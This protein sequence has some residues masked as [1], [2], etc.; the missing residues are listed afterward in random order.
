MAKT[1]EVMLPAL[2]ARGYGLFRLIWFA[3]LAVAIVAPLGGAYVRLA[4]H[5]VTIV[6]GLSLAIDLLPPV[7]LIATAVLLFLRRGR[8][9]VAA[10]LSLSF[11]LMCGSFFAAEGFF[12]AIELGWARGL[13]ATAGRCAL[14]LVLLTF[15][16]GKFRPRW[17][18]WLA[19]LLLLWGPIA[20][21]RPFPRDVEYLGYLAFTGLSVLAIALRY[22][23]LPQ[24]AERQQVRWVLF[25]FAA[26]TALLALALVAAMGFAGAE[27]SDWRRLV[28]QTLAAMGMA[29]FGLGLIVSLLRYR[30][31]DADA[32]ISRSAAYAMLTILLGAVFTASSEGAKI[33]IEA[34]FGRNAGALP[35]IFAAGMAA[36]LLAPANT[37][38][39]NWA[40]RR[41]QK[42]L[43]ALRR[44]LP[45]CVA[46]LRET[47]SMDQLLGEV[48]DRV[49][50]GVSAARA[51][52]LTGDETAAMRGVTDLEVARWR[53][54][55]AP[56]EAVEELDCDRADP[57][58][59]MRV[60][61]RVRHGESVPIGWILL[62][63]RPDGSFYGKDEREALAEIADPVARAVQIVSRREAREAR[64]DSR[65][66]A[67]EETL[68]GISRMTAPGSMG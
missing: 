52:V 20:F 4:G 33:V 45:E 9:T 10:L 34:S 17:T 3:A 32:A 1:G 50:S 65:L 30:L 58:F 26:G 22:R 59:P 64:L 60:P 36:V 24:G 29:C 62:G 37:L 27:T 18:L 47:G 46:D 13:I 41:F 44:D 67:L 11:L 56:D 25:G 49:Q 21:V 14:I 54:D 23:R 16:D 57:L 68:A 12:R 53:A 48:L 15:P 35:A 55:N 43:S 5:E 2:G 31:Y 7:L 61:L 40:E 66:T 63:A 38:L 28:A 51:V 42:R 19:L 8:D 39:S 6:G